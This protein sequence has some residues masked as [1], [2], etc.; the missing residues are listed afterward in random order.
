MVAEPVQATLAALSSAYNYSAD[1]VTALLQKLPDPVLWIRRW[2]PAATA[3]AAPPNLAAMVVPP[4]WAVW[5]AWAKHHQCAVATVLGAGLGCGGW[6]FYRHGARGERRRRRVPKLANGARRDV[7]LV[8]GSPTEPLTR[9]LALDFEK[10]GFIVYLTLLDDKDA[11]YVELNA[12][13]DDINF[14]SMAGAD[15]VDGAV[16]DFRRLLDTRVVPFAGAAAH[17]LRLRAVVFAPHLYFPLGPAEQVARASWARVQRLQAVPLD[18]FAAGLLDLVRHHRCKVVAVVPT[19]VS[20][21]ALP[22]HAPECVFQAGLK[23]YYAALAK[24]LRPHGVL[25]TQVRLGN[26]NLS[27][28]P[29]LA[30]VVD[31]EVRSWPDDMRQVYGDHF[32][33]TQKRAA[34]GSGLK[35]TG[36]RALHHLLFDLIFAPSSNPPVVYYGTGARA[37]EWLVCVLPTWLADWVF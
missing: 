35:S 3:A 7:V 9:L 27:R 21:L 22:Y 19:V 6:Y 10:R 33:R 31:A 20:T 28:H 8:V 2:N 36:L 14:L 1:L 24:E 32:L 25:V 15:G 29:R 34:V 26:L 37:Y 4:K 18:L 23:A 17:R 12:L 16:R 11:R 30:S 13:P 5:V